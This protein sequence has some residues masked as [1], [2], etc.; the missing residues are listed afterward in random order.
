MTGKPDPDH[1][2]GPG[3]AAFPST[4]K[5]WGWLRKLIY[6]ILTGLVLFFVG[7][8]LIASVGG[9]AWDELRLAPLPLTLG[10]LLLKSRF[11]DPGPAS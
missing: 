9:I 1:A 8:Y 2:D 5:R 10:V 3:T 7:R 11:T 4:V 6:L